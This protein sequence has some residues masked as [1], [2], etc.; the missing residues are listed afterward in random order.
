MLLRYAITV[1]IMWKK[2][3]SKEWYLLRLLVPFQYYIELP[4]CLYVFPS[5]LVELYLTAPLK[6]S[7]LAILRIPGYEA[8][9]EG[10][11]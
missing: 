8:G 6:V 5:I 1:V 7:S 2:G 4:N 9:A 3:G 11:W 10:F